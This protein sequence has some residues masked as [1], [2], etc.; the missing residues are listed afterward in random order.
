M[1]CLIGVGLD[2][3]IYSLQVLPYFRMR[4]FPVHLSLQQVLPFPLKLSSGSLFILFSAFF[5]FSV[6]HQ[7]SK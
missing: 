3:L 5:C 6:L 7:V 4:L 2:F 1:V